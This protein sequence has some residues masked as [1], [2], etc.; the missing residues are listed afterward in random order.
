[1]VQQLQ[2]QWSPASHTPDRLR[3]PNA[4]PR[5]NLVR[6]ETIQ[7]IKNFNKHRLTHCSLIERFNIL[8]MSILLKLLY[9]F[10]AIQMKTS[11]KIIFPFFLSL[12]FSHPFFLLFFISIFLIKWSYNLSGRIEHVKIARKILPKTLVRD[13]VL[14]NTEIYTLATNIM[15]DAYE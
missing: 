14:P 6:R 5:V 4:H 3:S 7:C 10:N 9:I 2:E 13:L 1:M 11:H 12:S 8:K 15:V